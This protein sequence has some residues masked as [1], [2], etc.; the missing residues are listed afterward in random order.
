MSD[1][2]RPVRRNVM[3]DRFTRLVA[4]DRG[5]I[6]DPSKNRRT[7]F[8]LAGKSRPLCFRQVFLTQY[9]GMRRT[10]LEFGQPGVAVFAFDRQGERVGAMCLASRSGEVRAGVIGRHSEVDLLLDHDPTLS[11]RHLVCVVEPPATLADAFR[12]DVRFRVLDLRS[13]APPRGEDGRPLASLT[14]EGPIFLRCCDF[15]LAAL[16]TGDEL[17]WPDD[18][19][20]AWECL[21]EQVLVEER[22]SIAIES[23]A[24]SLAR[25]APSRFHLTGAPGSLE[26]RRRT[27]QVWSAEPLLKIDRRDLVAARTGAS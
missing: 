4:L 26:H 23:G 14:A 16:V 2:L 6:R 18:A 21:P 24:R 20:E 19:M 8:P 10:A 27:T 7:R 15:V 5:Q 13:G 17:A 3:V 11:L 22:A 12:G 1:R 9:A 25:A